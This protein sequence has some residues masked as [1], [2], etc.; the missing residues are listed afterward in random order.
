MMKRNLCALALA[1]ASF[2]AHAG[3]VTVENFNAPTGTV[4]KASLEAKGYVF[5][6]NSDPAGPGTFT[7]GD[8]FGPTV[9]VG[10]GQGG[11]GGYLGANYTGAQ[12]GG[13]L[14]QWL[15][16]PLFDTSNSGSISFYLRGDNAPGYFDT[17]Q[18]GLLTAAGLDL[19]DA[20]TVPVADWT[21]FTYNFA[22][23]GISGSRGRFAIRYF[24]PA[25]TSNAI[26][27]DTLRVSVP[28]P[29]SV[30]LLGMGM[31]GLIAARRRKVPQ[32]GLRA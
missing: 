15:Y 32:A 6:N 4:L 20:F 24:G 11:S 27:I 19:V 25:D 2:T 3:S 17:V 13:F 8:L 5:I 10:V 31:V 16:T 23:S 30:M 12:D 28:E 18:Y 1:A 7:Q 29:T 9:G 26:G 14:D 22:A 21:Q